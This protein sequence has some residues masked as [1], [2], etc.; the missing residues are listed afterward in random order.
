MIAV[1]RYGMQQVSL[2]AGV[3]LLNNLGLRSFYKPLILL[4]VTKPRGIKFV[5]V[6]ALL[7]ALLRLK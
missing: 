5:D 6:G 7:R 1:L 4:P 3:G 2:V